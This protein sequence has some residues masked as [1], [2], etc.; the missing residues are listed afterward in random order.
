M[1]AENSGFDFAGVRTAADGA[2]NDVLNKA[3]VSGGSA[4]DLQKFYTAL[5][6]VFQNPNIASDVNGQ[7]RGFDNAVHTASHP[8]YQNYSGWT[9]TGP[10]RH[11]WP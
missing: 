9:S 3:Q 11:W 10:G 1:A 4:A 6:H 2:W 7:Y 5:Y 8:I